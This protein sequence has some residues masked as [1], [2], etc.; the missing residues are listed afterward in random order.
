MVIIG[1]TTIKSQLLQLRGN[2]PH[3]IVGTPRRIN[4][5]IR[6]KLLSMDFLKIVIFEY[7]T[8][9]LI[10]DFKDSI[11]EL[12]TNNNILS[13]QKI[14]IDESDNNPDNELSFLEDYMYQPVKIHY[15]RNEEIF[16]SIIN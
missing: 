13:A 15:R 3:I 11:K 4:Y 5:L 14:L 8:E 16:K 2:T 7:I 12:F 10:R 9:I 1:G 6:R